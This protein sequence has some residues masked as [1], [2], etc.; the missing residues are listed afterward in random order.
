M[1]FARTSEKEREKKLREVALCR[2]VRDEI[3]RR[4]KTDFR[5]VPSRDEPADVIL[6]SNSGGYPDR[7]VQLV[8][9]PR[10]FAT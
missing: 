8:T 9:I 10:D 4:E 1:S 7:R 3:N 6:R 2:P 5:V